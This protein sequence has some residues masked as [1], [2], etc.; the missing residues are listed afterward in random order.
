MNVL[1]RPLVDSYRRQLVRFVMG[2]DQA[3]ATICEELAAHGGSEEFGS[4]EIS[5]VH[6]RALAAALEDGSG[7][8]TLSKVTAERAVLFREQV[9]ATLPSVE[10]PELAGV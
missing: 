3:V 7:G 10:V 4:D 1:P 5:D 6:E 8:M 2:D 9:E